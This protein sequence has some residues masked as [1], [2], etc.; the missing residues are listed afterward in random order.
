M[1]CPGRRLLFSPLQ[2]DAGTSTKTL[3]FLPHCLIFPT[4]CITTNSPFR[5][6]FYPRIN[7]QRLTLHILTQNTFG[8]RFEIQVVQNPYHRRLIHRSSPACRLLDV[9]AGKRGIQLL[10]GSISS[11]HITALPSR[12]Y[13]R[14]V[15]TTTE[16]QPEPLR[17]RRNTLQRMLDLEKRNKV[18]LPPPKAIM[19]AHWLT[20]DFV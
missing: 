18:C 6:R 2:R 1:R 9:T 5:G 4:G 7:S 20:A 8:P 14:S 3:T 15:M 12:E 17:P 10:S 13:P 11:H 16:R 19:T